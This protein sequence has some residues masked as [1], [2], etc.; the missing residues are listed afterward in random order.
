MCA[1]DKYGLL[2]EINPWMH[3]DVQPDVAVA[4]EQWQALYGILTEEIGVNVELVTQADSAPDMVFTANAGL[5][6][7]GRALLSRFRH[8]ERQVEVPHFRRWF[9]S[10]GYACVEPPED[11]YFE[12][13]GDSLFTGE[14]LVAGYLKRSDIRA[15]QWVAA[16]L[17]IQVLSLELTDPR[18]YH[19]DT[20]FFALSPTEIVYYPGAFD[21]YARRVLENGFDTLTVVEDEALR[22]ACNSIV[23]G[24]TIVMPAGCPRLKSDLESRGKTVHAVEMSEFLKCGGAS[25]C[26]T[27]F[28][29]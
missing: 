29:R 24:D 2:Y 20:A 26:L 18:W 9:E 19:L 16:E 11:V 25:K 17:G 28:L 4:A 23:L 8:P 21:E 6:V 13:E 14:V 3:L 15:H 1:P 10:N 7:P 27:L 12:G 5:A 22:F